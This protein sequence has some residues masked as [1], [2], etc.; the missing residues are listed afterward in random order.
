VATVVP[1]ELDPAFLKQPPARALDEALQAIE[2]RYGRRTADVVA[3]QLGY[4]A[5]L[6]RLAAVSREQLAALIREAWRCQAPKKLLGNESLEVPRGD[7]RRRP[8][9]ADGRRRRG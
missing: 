4:P 9:Q 3:V 6:V 8:R 2:G 1:E 7:G 5:V